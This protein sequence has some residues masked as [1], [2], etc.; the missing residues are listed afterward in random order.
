MPDFG[1]GLVGGSLG[2]L[3]GIVSAIWTLLV[4]KEA[5]VKPAETWL[6]KIFGAQG[7]A[8]LKIAGK[9]LITLPPL[10]LGG[11]WLVTKDSFFRTTVLAGVNLDSIRPVYMVTLMLTYVFIIGYPVIRLIIKVGNDLG[12]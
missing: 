6:S 10:W 2:A 1:S 7:G 5:T 11:S 12:S 8:G 4:L 3:I 9:L